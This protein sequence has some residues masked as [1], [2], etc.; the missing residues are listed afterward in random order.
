MYL[1]IGGSSGLGKNLANYL[2]NFD[3]VLVTYRNIKNLKKIKSKK[4]KIYYKK[5]N[6]KNSKDI[7]IFIKNNNK[8]LK[9]IKFINLA[10]MTL[11]K[12]ITNIDIKNIEDIFKVNVYSNIVFAKFLLPKMIRD[13]FGRFIFFTSTRASR[14]D[15]GISLYSSSKQA[16]AGFSRSLS[17][18]YAKFNV[19]SNCLKLGYFESK[20]FNNINKKVRKK[21]IKEIPSGKLGN[22]R[23]LLSM[24]K[25]ISDN[26][27]INGAEINIDGGI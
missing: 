15:I 20:L 12:I 4:N 11:D 3:D 9:N 1:I 13:N 18:E 16:L 25:T 24:V 10:T 23:D 17:K 21:L 8:L 14:G 22:A 27:Y 5:L 19:T 7:K 2:L 6:L 26:N